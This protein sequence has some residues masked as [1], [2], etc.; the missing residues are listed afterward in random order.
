MKYEV[1][2]EFYEENLRLHQKYN[3]ETEDIYDT[4]NLIA[5][6]K[7]AQRDFTTSNKLAREAIR[8]YLKAD[9]DYY[10]TSFLSTSALLINNYLKMK[11]ADSAKIYLKQAL[12]Y[13]LTRQRFTTDFLHLRAKLAT[14]EE[15]YSKAVT[16][17]K[18]ALHI[19]E[20]EDKNGDEQA[21]LLKELGDLL[22]LQNES[23]KAA[24]YYQQAMA[25]F[26]EK[27]SSPGNTGKGRAYTLS[28]IFPVIKAY[29]QLLLQTASEESYTK[30]LNNGQATMRYLN[31]LRKKDF[32]D[33]DKQVLVANVIPILESSLEASYQLSKITEKPGYIDTAFEFIE[34]SK[35]PV[36]LDA[37]L[38]NNATHFA[39][40]PDSLLEKERI[41]KITIASLEKD[42]QLSEEDKKNE[43]F[44]EK[45]NY[46]KFI[47]Q[48]ET[49]YP[50]YYD[51]KYE[52]NTVALKQLQQSI[53]SGTKVLSY[54]Y[55]TKDIYV[56]AISQNSE[57]FIKIAFTQTDVQNL[58]AYQKQLG[59]PRSDLT[60]LNIISNALYKKLLA[61]F[62]QD[63][64]LEKLLI[65][66]D[67][68]LRTIPFEAMN[69]S[70]NQTKYLVENTA[71][72]YANSA[73]LWIQAQ[74]SPGSRP[75]LAAFA[76]NFTNPG[77]NEPNEFLPL[78]GNQPEVE[79]IATFFKGDT[80]LN[81]EASLD[82]FTHL[83]RDHTIIHLAT[84]AVANDETPEYSFLAFTPNKMSP[85]LLYVN[86]IYALELAVDLVTLS[87]CETGVGTLQKGEGVISL[88]RAFFYS[89]A[90]SLVYTLWNINDTS[91]SSI[92]GSFYE[93]LADG[94]PKDLALQEAKKSFLE[95]N[96]ETALV[97]PYYWSGFIIQ[98]NT[99]P[100]IVKSYTSFY[101]LGIG[102]FLWMLWFFR[103]ILLK[104]I[105]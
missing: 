96:K 68:P 2:E 3:H 89:G 64:P 58:L 55:G 76:P 26:P 8:Y 92:M 75:K 95:H 36:L 97:H 19:L 48:L 93:K 1:A 41:L 38:R 13:T 61:P 101:I 67:G 71:C 103:K 50:S 77:N 16:V 84:H 39:G 17:Y 47:S 73:T 22:A 63:L 20:K 56:L 46:E 45:R 100:L 65:I 23:E 79:K 104:L 42:I 91:S 11:E 85:Y 44:I 4:K 94:M 62:V 74:A 12:P 35:S 32:G 54:F 34:Q 49:D 14:L 81:E 18:E 82:S 60:Q 78:V 43:L 27:T 57:E 40:I 37:I 30:A 70:Q 51:L 31:I 98:G 24:S 53:P 29:N 10:D 6:L 90:K 21:G 7:S 69:T 52:T 59:D 9:P 25:L 86:D 72:S 33:A 66:P 83:S 105:E 80:F 99:Q 15:N 88:A 102:L 5:S 87:A 28:N